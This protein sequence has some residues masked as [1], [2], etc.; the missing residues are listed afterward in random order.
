MV[1]GVNCVRIL[2]A[3]VLEVFE[4]VSLSYLL[5]FFW[6]KGFGNGRKIRC[7]KLAPFL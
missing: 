6:G 3:A 5:D 1:Y 2:P 4:A 7:P